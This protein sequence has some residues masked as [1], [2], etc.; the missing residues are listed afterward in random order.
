MFSRNNNSFYIEEKKKREREQKE[1]ALKHVILRGG[2]ENRACRGSKSD[3]IMP[4]VKALAK[5]NGY[6]SKPQLI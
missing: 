4:S 1:T 3:K 5:G 2:Q 6:C